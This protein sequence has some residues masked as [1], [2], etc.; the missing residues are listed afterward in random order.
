M[1]ATLQHYKLGVRD[2]RVGDNCSICINSLQTPQLVTKESA[3]GHIFQGFDV[4][5]YGS[6]NHMALNEK[7]LANFNFWVRK[8]NRPKHLFY[9][10]RGPI[11]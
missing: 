6:L 1:T 10:E 8:L 2:P 9:I 5:P 4:E 11:F 3:N 7:G